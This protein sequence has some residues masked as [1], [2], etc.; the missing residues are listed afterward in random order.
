MCS[1]VF[2]LLQRDRHRG[3]GFRG[4]CGVQGASEKGWIEE[5]GQTQNRDGWI[6]Q[7]KRRGDDE[8]LTDMGLEQGQAAGEVEETRCSTME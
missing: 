3:R 4:H 1:G 8:N 7:R 5:S 2:T 6:G